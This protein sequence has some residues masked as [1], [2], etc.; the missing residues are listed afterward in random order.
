[1]A[2]LLVMTTAPVGAQDGKPRGG[3]AASGTELRQWATQAQASSEYPGWEA[4]NAVG[5]PTITQCADQRGA[6]ASQTWDGEREEWLLVTFATPVI[7]TQ[8]NIHQNF[9]PG[10]ITRLVVFAEG[11]DE[12]IILPNSAD[13][14]PIDCPNVF[15]YDVTTITE[16]II[17]VGMY[18]D[19]RDQRAWT[20]IDAVE[21][22]GVAGDGTT[23]TT[24]GGGSGGG[25]PSGGSAAGGPNSTNTRANAPGISIV[26]PQGG[27]FDNGVQ[28]TINMRAGFSYTATVLGIGDFDPIVAVTDGDE[29]LCNDDSS[30]AAEFIVDLPTSGEVGPSTL[31]AQMPFTYSGSAFGDV[32]F[33]VGSVGSTAGE[34]VLLIEGLA[35][36]S[37]DGSGDGAGDPFYLSLSENI[38]AS[39]VDIS[40]YMISVTND[41]DSL[42]YVV[43]EDDRMIVLEDG[44]AAV[45]DDANTP[46]CYGAPDVSLQG[47]FVTR[48]NGRRLP[49]G[50]FDSLFRVPSDI[51]T[52]GNFLEY[53]FSSPGQR[54]FGDYVAA[55]HLGTTAP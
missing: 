53:R 47:A 29:T 9:N 2:L 5:A 54:T 24:D 55:F 45:C 50:Q 8:I 1:M 42:I 49:T 18:L 38:I 46:S 35:V 34:F 6:W 52:A 51:F 26:C 41:L 11:S 48:T 27:G 19:Q 3:G 21:L 28:V 32:S 31:S 44:T 16:P 22:V 40:A 30:A 25:G 33:V 10:S 23:P 39:G 12:Q 43:G 36:T 13:L 37:N 15:S 20:E 17:A 7:P 4:V 14:N